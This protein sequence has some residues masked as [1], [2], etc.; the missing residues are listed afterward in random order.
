M[1]VSS[2]LAAVVALAI[3]AAVGCASP[4]DPS[5]DDTAAGTEA[6]LSS[7]DGSAATDPVLLANAKKFVE[8]IQGAEGSYWSS[9]GKLHRI[10][11]QDLPSKLAKS[12][13]KDNP[14]P[15][16]EWAAVA[17]TTAVLDSKG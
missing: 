13:E 17:L 10:A 7:S 9:E 11:Y 3:S 1:N 15:K 8:D 6:A 5:S 16:E 12:V 4:A 14:D 2:L